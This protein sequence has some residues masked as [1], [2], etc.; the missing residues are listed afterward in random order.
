M[1]F[2]TLI[3]GP[4]IP[5]F[6]K[7]NDV[8]VVVH[9]Y[10]TTFSLGDKKEFFYPLRLPRRP[11]KSRVVNLLYVQKSNDSESTLYFPVVVSHYRVIKPISRWLSSQISRHESPD[12]YICNY[13]LK[14]LHFNLDKDKYLTKMNY[15]RGRKKYLTST[16]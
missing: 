3:D 15:S 5:T 13:C 10:D 8:S 1:S 2:P 6:E 12:N 11:E 16:S 7:Y 14:S 9:A 4:D